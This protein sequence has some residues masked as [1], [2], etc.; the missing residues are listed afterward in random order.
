ME[1]SPGPS[2][3]IKCAHCKK[4][5]KNVL[6]HIG[7]NKTCES[8]YPKDQLKLL[9]EN[10][11]S[12][13]TEKKKITRKIQEATPQRKEKRAQHDKTFR[14]KHR[15]KRRQENQLHYQ[16]HKQEKKDYYQKNKSK[17][18]KAYKEN[19]K[20]LQNFFKEIQHGPIYPCISCMRCLPL[21]SVR[22]LTDKFYH[23]LCEQDV[24]KYVSRQ[25]N[26]QI[27]N[28]WHLCST[29]YNNLYKGNLPSQCQENGLKL[30]PVPDCLKISDAGNQLL[31][32]NLVFIKV[33]KLKHF[34]ILNI[35]HII[36]QISGSKVA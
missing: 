4:Y 33:C 5:F 20:C 35:T 2:N 14:E 36:I 18:A 34:Q 19:K 13:T 28:S 3:K 8:N 11:K 21:R 25:P 17:I 27:N 30:A 12:K 9:R 15:D 10:A 29:C 31:A 6:I 1:P 7:L 23:K 22:K 32:K 24:A 26:L 16:N